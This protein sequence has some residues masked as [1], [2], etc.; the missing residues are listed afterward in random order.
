[1]A[2]YD[3]PAGPAELFEAVREAFGKHLGGEQHMRLGGGTVLAARWA[4][5]HSTDVDLFTDTESYVRLWQRRDAFRRTIERRTAP[6]ELSVRQWNTKIILPDGEVT[7]FTS[8]PFTNQPRSADTVRNTS[9]P[10]ETNAEILAKKLGGRMLNTGALVLRDLYDFAVARHHDPDAIKTS[11]QR[12]DVSDLKQLKREIDNLPHDWARSP[13]QRRLI[14]PVHPAEASNP[15]P[16]VADQIRREI[17]SRVPARPRRS[18]PAW[19][20]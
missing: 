6:R 18:P 19:E 15:A 16:F 2:E 7:L 13:G 14:R 10:F 12:I 1:M 20:R 4:H 11:V 9:V 8:P 5:R 3:L 17:L